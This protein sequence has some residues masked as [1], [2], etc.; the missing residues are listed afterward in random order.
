M[1][2]ENDKAG[3]EGKRNE[4]DGT[5]AA[6]LAWP[7]KVALALQPFGTEKPGQWFTHAAIVRRVN[8][9]YGTDL[10]DAFQHL[11]DL[12]K[13]GHVVR[14]AKPHRIKDKFAPHTTPEYIYQRTGKAFKAKKT[15]AGAALQKGLRTKWDHGR[16]PKWFRDMM[17]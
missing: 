4:R 16:L 9:R 10:I 3:K 6:R 12:I 8:E 7:E 17:Q 1:K 5:N 15:M 14:A 2:P 13:S 11:Y